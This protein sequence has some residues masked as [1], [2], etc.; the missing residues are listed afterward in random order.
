VYTK[1]K[2]A[3]TETQDEDGNSEDQ[4]SNE[5]CKVRG[6]EASDIGAEIERRV[7]IYVA[8]PQWNCRL[9][10]G[11]HFYHGNDA[12]DEIWCHYGRFL[13]VSSGPIIVFSNLVAVE[14]SRTPRT[15]KPIHVWLILFGSLVKGN[16]MGRV[17]EQD[18]H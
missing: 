3:T 5:V 14:F 11:V 6:E 17:A 9:K 18:E 10:I 4:Y 13:G 12:T 15:K 16:S 8:I 7:C 1:P 2:K